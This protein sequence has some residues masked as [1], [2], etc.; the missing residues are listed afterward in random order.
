MTQPDKLTIGDVEALLNYKSEADIAKLDAAAENIA[1]HL[2][3]T[4]RENEELKHDVKRLMAMNTDLLNSIR[5]QNMDDEEKAYA[6]SVYMAINGS[7]NESAMKEALKE[8]DRV[9][10]Y[11]HTDD[12][13]YCKVL[14]TA[15]AATTGAFVCLKCNTAFDGQHICSTQNTVC[16]HEWIV[17]CWHVIICR[18]CYTDHNPPFELLAG[19]KFT[20]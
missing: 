20:Y 3:D 19:E 5:I 8:Y 12:T 9:N 11:K 13:V 18:K 1:R 16:D 14:T 17:T 7:V 6:C 15:I 4:M 10:S 2:A